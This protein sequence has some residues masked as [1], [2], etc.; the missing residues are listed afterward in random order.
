MINN[1]IETG[2]PTRL[3]QGLWT[4]IFLPAIIW[5]TFLIA[6]CTSP[7]RPSI[8]AAEAGAVWPVATPITGVDL[9]DVGWNIPSFSVIEFDD[10]GKLQDRSQL[11]NTYGIIKE[12]HG[13]HP[14][15][16]LMFVHGWKHSA[17]EIDSNRQ[18]FYAF[19]TNVARAHMVNPS[20][21]EY[22]VVGVYLGWRGN[23]FDFEQE[24]LQSVFPFQIPTALAYY[25]RDEAAKRV[26]GVTASEA[27]LSLAG[28]AKARSP[29]GITN[30]QN[31]PDKIFD[32]D[33]DG[34]YDETKDNPR[35]PPDPMESRV[36]IAGHSMGGL[37]VE[38]AVAQSLI[39]HMAINN[40]QYQAA[41]LFMSNPRTGVAAAMTNFCLSRQLLD[42]KKQD[43]AAKEANLDHIDLQISLARKEVDQ[44]KGRQTADRIRREQ[45]LTLISVNTNLMT[46]SYAVLNGLRTNLGRSILAWTNPSP[47]DISIEQPA[48]SL[49]YVNRRLNELQNQLDDT[50]HPADLALGWS[51]IVTN[52]TT[53]RRL[54]DELQRGGE[55]AWKKN[56]RQ[57]ARKIETLMNIKPMASDYPRVEAFLT[58]PEGWQTNDELKKDIQEHSDTWINSLSL[59]S[60][61]TAKLE[62]YTQLVSNR[63][64]TLL[65][66]VDKNDGSHVPFVMLAGLGDAA[67]HANKYLG[68]VKGQVSGGESTFAIQMKKNSEAAEEW[69]KL[70]DGG[71]LPTLSKLKGLAAIGCTNQMTSPTEAYRC[72]DEGSEAAR[73]QREDARKSFSEAEQKHQ[74]ARDALRNLASALFIRSLMSET[75]P[76]DLILLINPASSALVA[77]QFTD[78]LNN[79]TINLRLPTPGTNAAYDFHLPGNRPLIINVSS[80]GDSATRVIFRIAHTIASFTKAFP[81]GPLGLWGDEAK[82]YR[83][84]AAHLPEMVTH[85]MTLNTNETAS[86]RAKTR[87]IQQPG[88]SEFRTNEYFLRINLLHGNG[89]VDSGGS[90]H[91]IKGNEIITPKGIYTITATT[92]SQ[93]EY[94]VVDCAP[95]LL[96]S[97]NEFWTPEFYATV[98]SLIRVRR[99]F[100]MTAPP[101][102]LSLEKAPPALK[103]K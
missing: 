99:L 25:N 103:T 30:W 91:E 83:N 34:I 5:A 102:T 21:N 13:R 12:L 56:F 46:S 10:M 62:G 82:G 3:S 70:P 38:R 18:S 61:L 92:N 42:T 39:G 29:N 45:L 96:P 84:A 72:C 66:A 67:T 11:D 48:A 37:I 14:I 98:A 1:D 16:L 94:W 8:P 28:L 51:K 58:P 95:A 90:N 79:Q 15:M 50:S 81:G 27:I 9:P 53:I 73:T 23:I 44:W 76:A 26:A 19:V 74:Q 80:K 63:V 89:W 35:L 49:D 88:L 36:V 78:A 41:D 59:M 52:L 100:D 22:A 68:I 85:I 20:G 54:E 47:N 65:I 57:E 6:G 64:E 40:A 17:T 87:P 24:N 77:R 4:C 75:V 43:L 33:G 71:V 55:A 69:K 97:H 60:R 2:V 31:E 32:T 101:K 86:W 93:S 7:I